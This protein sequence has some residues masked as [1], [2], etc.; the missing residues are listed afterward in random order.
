[1]DF[2]A[3]WYE[4]TPYL[5]AIVGILSILHIGSV[6]GICFGLFLVISAGLIILLRHNY[7]RSQSGKRKHQITT[8]R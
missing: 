8:M 5:Y 4:Y 2:E 7:R 3:I 6:I 1:M